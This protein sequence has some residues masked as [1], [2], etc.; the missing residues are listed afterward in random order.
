MGEKI[1]SPVQSKDLSYEMR[2]YLA[3]T[4]YEELKPSIAAIQPN[5]KLHVSV[6]N[7]EHR[8]FIDRIGTHQ[9]LKELKKLLASDT[10]ASIFQIKT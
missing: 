9:P 4:K 3:T 10:F 1:Y 7:D 5:K 8:K 6:K 2:N